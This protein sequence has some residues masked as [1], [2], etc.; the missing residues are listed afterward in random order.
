MD[1]ERIKR[2]LASDA[3]FRNEVKA[4]YANLVKEA[5]NPFS[6]K[7]VAGMA[8]VMTGASILG[9]TLS[10]ETAGALQRLKSKV[11]ARGNFN[12][13]M[14]E[15]PEL[16]HMDKRQ[17]QLAFNTLQRFNPEF[18]SD[19][20]VSGAWTRQIAGYGEGVPV[21]RLKTVTD[22]ASALAKT[23]QTALSGQ[24]PLVNAAESMRKAQMGG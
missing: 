12:R 11:T 5:A 3:R 21:D 13:M 4:A 7:Q 15:N 6:A 24:Q 14:K 23:K 22:A 8:A 9:S 19:P 17:V 2:K 16:K 1:V 20:L 18:A 10:Q